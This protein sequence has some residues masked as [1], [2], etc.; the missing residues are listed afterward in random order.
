MSG[1]VLKDQLIEV[2]DRGDLKRIFKE[3]NH[4][5]KELFLF[6]SMEAFMPFDIFDKAFDNDY[7]NGQKDFQADMLINEYF[8]RIV[9]LKDY[10][11]FI[12]LRFETNSDEMFV[13]N[14]K[15]LSKSD[16]NIKLTM[17]N[18]FHSRTDTTLRTLIDLMATSL[19][20]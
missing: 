8:Y 3:R 4:G 5:T 6:N 7:D 19:E 18:I 20:L 11:L 10:Y 17:S 14:C 2:S 9:D 12:G 1:N 15:S 13:Y 16:M